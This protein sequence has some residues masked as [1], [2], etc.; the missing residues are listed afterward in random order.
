MPLHGLGA[1][2]CVSAPYAAMLLYHLWTMLV[3]SS[4]V[5][6]L[7]LEIDLVVYVG[8]LNETTQTSLMQTTPVH[9]MYSYISCVYKIGA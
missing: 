1:H 8:S 4:R 6:S 7:S 5:P 9:H 2:A 3:V